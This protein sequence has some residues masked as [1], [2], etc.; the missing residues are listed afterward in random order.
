MVE[1]RAM[2]ERVRAPKLFWAVE[3][4]GHVDLESYAPAA[5][6]DNVLAFLIE[7]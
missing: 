1:T 6:R 4:A 2:F 5:Y 7:R 3:G